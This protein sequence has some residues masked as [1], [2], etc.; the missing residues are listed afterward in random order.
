M[1]PT[2]FWGLT[3]SIVSIP[4]KER[5]VEQQFMDCQTADE[6]LPLVENWLAGLLTQQK[7]R[8]YMKKIASVYE[9]IA[10]QSHENLLIQ[11][12]SK[13]QGCSV[14]T[15]ERHFK[16]GIGISPKQYQRIVRFNHVISYIRQHRFINWTDIV[17]QFGYYDQPHFIN[18]FNLFYGKTPTAFSIQE[19]LL[20]SIVQ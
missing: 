5:R 12:I 18:D 11:K 6:L 10:Q 20:S 4:A 1:V 17:Y 16:E 15:L 8:H 7:E 9:Y 2:E 13:K 14:R 19:K 3:S